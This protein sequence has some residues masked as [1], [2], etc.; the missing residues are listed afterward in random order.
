MKTVTLALLALTVM[1][2]ILSGC[3]ADSSR[4][5]TPVEADVFRCTDKCMVARYNCNLD[6]FDGAR[7]EK[8]ACINNCDKVERDC[9]KKCD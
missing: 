4:F 9:L 1:A 6:C 7:S 2:T 3:E 5:F 8:K